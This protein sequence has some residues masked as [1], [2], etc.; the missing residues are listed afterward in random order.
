MML[1]VCGD[2]H[3]LDLVQRIEAVLFAPGKELHDGLGIGRPRIP[4]PDRRRKKFNEA[5]GGALA[6]ALDRPSALVRSSNTPQMPACIGA[7]VCY[8]EEP[9]KET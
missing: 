1:D 4:V 7:R 6:G 8:Y 3:R 9:P 2:D 5:P